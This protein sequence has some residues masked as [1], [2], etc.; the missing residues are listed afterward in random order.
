M[1]PKTHHRNGFYV[2]AILIGRKYSGLISYPYIGLGILVHWSNSRS[3]ALR[4][5]QVMAHNKLTEKIKGNDSYPHNP[6]NKSIWG[7][8][9]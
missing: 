5:G 8:S 3:S 9:D 6:G 2:M 4:E 1:Q 7:P